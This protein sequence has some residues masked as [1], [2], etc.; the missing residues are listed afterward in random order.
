[1]A[2][3]QTFYIEGK[4]FQTKAEFKDFV[5]TILNKY[6]LNKPI[7][8]A[9]FLF[10]SELLKRHPEYD[11][12]IGSGIKAIVIKI[13]GNWGKTRCFHIQRTD[14]TET[15]FSYIHCIDYDTSREPM[16]MFK[17]SSRSA[18]KDQ[19][20][21]HLSNYIS[22]TKDRNG[23]II[24]QKSQAKINKEQA[25]VDHIPPI[26]FDRI[27]SDFL[28]IKNIEPSKIEYIG[29]GDNEYRKEFKD[30]N[31]KIEFANYHKQVAKLR[32]ISKQENLTQKKKNFD[33][34]LK[35]EF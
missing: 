9:D 10:I 34:Q 2:K 22:R 20:I 31:L 1:M 27:V 7:D 18:V 12:K 32:I 35:I 26:T 23:N 15:D 8:A 4:T 11:R 13:D 17:Q 19:I 24:C 6:E 3:R 16:K 33:E 14:G 21:S 30:E 29:F 25:E 5:K 28:L